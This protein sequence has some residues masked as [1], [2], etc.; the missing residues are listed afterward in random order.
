MAGVIHVHHLIPLSS[1]DADYE[2][3]PVRDLRP[4]CPNCHVVLHHREPPYSLEEA[5]QFLQRPVCG[6]RAAGRSNALTGL[7]EAEGRR[8]L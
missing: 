2:V 6:P 4:V 5:R 7:I 3:D 8:Q 1:V